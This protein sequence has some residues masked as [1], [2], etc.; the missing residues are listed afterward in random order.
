MVRIIDW[1][2]CFIFVHQTWN[3]QFGYG[4]KKSIHEVN[5]K[6]CKD[7]LES[8]RHFK[9]FL[10]DLQMLTIHA[11]SPS[12]LESRERV[13]SQTSPFGELTIV[14]RSI[15]AQRNKRTGK[16]QPGMNK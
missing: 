10:I 9:G 1:P 8:R 14:E 15:N 2:Y 12:S 13:D 6:L 7:Q 3:Q 5:G 11:I 16:C 4:R